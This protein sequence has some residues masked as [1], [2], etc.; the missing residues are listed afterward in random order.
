MSTARC[1]CAPTIGGPYT[2]STAIRFVCNPPALATNLSPEIKQR[3][4]RA[5]PTTKPMLPF[6]RNC[7]F[8]YVASALKR[9]IARSGSARMPDGKTFYDLPVGLL[10]NK[11]TTV[12][13]EV[14]GV[15]KM[16]TNLW[17]INCM[18]E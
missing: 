5:L 12:R 1:D 9:A 16:A 11:L 13:T 17:P 6:F 10:K 2:A 7:S 15:I 14:L 3:L 18:R 8:C 4:P